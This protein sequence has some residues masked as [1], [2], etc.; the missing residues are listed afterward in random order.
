[1][2]APMEAA[3]KNQLVEQAL[4]LSPRERAKLITV[5]A[6]SLARD[7]DDTDT[8]FDMWHREI[9]GALNQMSDDLTSG[10]VKPMTHEE[11][12]GERF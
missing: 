1:M 11:V 12:F 5:L 4:A 3:Q 6:E 9:V 8:D 2:I 7:D 10:R